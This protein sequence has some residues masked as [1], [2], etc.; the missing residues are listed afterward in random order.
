MKR[1]KKKASAHRARLLGFPPRLAH[2]LRRAVDAVIG[3]SLNMASMYQWYGT[4]FLHH[5]SSPATLSVT[6][7]GFEDAEEEWELA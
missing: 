6:G 2:L 4:T 3:Q 5:S 1:E 7:T